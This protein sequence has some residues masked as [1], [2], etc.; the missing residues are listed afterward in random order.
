M[1]STVMNNAKSGILEQQYLMP[2]SSRRLFL[3]KSIANIVVAFVQAI[4]ILIA[5]MAIS[6]HWISFPVIMIVPFIL[7]LLTTVGLGYLI[8]SLVLRFKRIGSTLVIFQYIY[9]GILLVNFENYSNL[10]K[11]LSCLLPICPMVSWMR[12]AVNNRP[13]NLAFYLSESIFNTVLWLIIGLLVFN[14]ADKYVKK[15][16]TLSFY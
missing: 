14:L 7:A 8:V 10:T 3:N 9:L 12:L 2:I 1:G 6:D 5:V 13:Y 11:C 16:G 15:N 4:L